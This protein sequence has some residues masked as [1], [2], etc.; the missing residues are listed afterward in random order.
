MREVKDLRNVRPDDIK[1]EYNA[2]EIVSIV[3]CRDA[4]MDM[5]IVV[6]YSDGV[7]NAY[8]I[9][10]RCSLGTK[11]KFFYKPKQ[12]KYLKPLHVVMKEAGEYAI[13][14]NGS[15]CS[16]VWDIAIITGMMKFFGG[17]ADKAGAYFYEKSWIEIKEEE[18]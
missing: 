7:S 6:V 3:Y 17:R 4:P 11:R 5:K 2:Y 13:N 15:I 12:V 8:T 10:G 16:S 14:S 1:H 18:A 9:D